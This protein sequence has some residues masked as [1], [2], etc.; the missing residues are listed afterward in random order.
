MPSQ[1]HIQIVDSLD[2]GL[3]YAESC[4]ETFRVVDGAI[5]LWDKHWQRLNQ[6]LRSFGFD[7]VKH[8]E[9]LASCLQAAQQQGNDVLIRLTVS[10]GDA[11]W[12]LQQSTTPN[13]YIQATAYRPP[14]Q[15]LLLQSVEYPFPLRTKSAKFSADYAHTLQALQ[16][17]QLETPLSPLVCKDG[18]II[19]GITANIALW[20]DGMW[21][22]PEGKGILPGCVRQY[23][24]EQGILLTT[25]CPSSMLEKAQA[26]VLLNSGTF[27][28][29][30]EGMNGKLL[31]HEHAAIHNIKQMLAHQQGVRL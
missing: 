9:V 1:S 27:I 2:R 8:D 25:S 24:I 6:G 16:H 18:F 3:S 4:F 10:G 7:I 13:I 5:F 28:Q 17:W 21:L 11:P 14:T 26:A 19:G 20:V 30:V 23:L 15:H 12:G 29:I 31:E 22:T